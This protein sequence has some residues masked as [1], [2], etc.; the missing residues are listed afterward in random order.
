VASPATPVSGKFRERQT[1]LGPEPD[2]ELVEV[3][4][5]VLDI[6]REMLSPDEAERPTADELQEMW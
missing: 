5:K 6:L 3:D 1:Y 2:G 4:Q